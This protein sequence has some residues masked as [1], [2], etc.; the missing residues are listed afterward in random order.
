MPMR[1]HIHA[2]LLAVLALCAF[3]PPAHAAAPACRGADDAP[4]A[5]NRD[6]ARAATLCL[7]NA[8]RA[9]HGLRSLSENSRL[10]RA[11]ERYSRDMVRRRFFDHV[12]PD[13]HDLV[14]R[15][16]AVSYVRRSGGWIAGENIA[17]GQGSSST[18]RQIVRA[19]MNSQGHR[20]NILNGRFR[21]IGLGIAPGSPGHGAGDEA[22]TYTTDFGTVTGR[23]ASRRRAHRSARR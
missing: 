10:T 4:T 22:A 7:L 9:K 13:G 8:E 21:E 5:A 11:S 12:D 2:A 1:R 19:W 20:E 6:E 17:W 15:L 18:P 3:A 23:A 16:R 14:D